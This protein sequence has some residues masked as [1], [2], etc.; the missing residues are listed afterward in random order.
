MW[1]AARNLLSEGDVEPESVVVTDGVSAFRTHDISLL[2]ST[3]RCQF[4]STATTPTPDILLDLV[5]ETFGLLGETPIAQLGINH[6]AHVPS[7][8]QTWDTVAAQL[9]DPHRRFVLLDDQRLATIELQA[10]RDDKHQGKRAIHLQPSA[11]LE[12]GVWFQ[13]NDHVS[14]ADPPETAMGAKDAM[15][16]LMDVWQSSRALADHVL[17]Q[18]APGQ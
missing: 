11:L 1:F 5:T 15:D 18:I 14:V 10:D 16:A 3:D 12:D 8:E 7:S 13:L 4:G 6:Q 17:Q 2:C 9:G